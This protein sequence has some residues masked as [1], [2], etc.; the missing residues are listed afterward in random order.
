MTT[1][2]AQRMFAGSAMFWILRPDHSG[3]YQR[4]AKEHRLEWS[5]STGPEEMLNLETIVL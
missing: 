4:R 2:N 3:F 5:V 1:F